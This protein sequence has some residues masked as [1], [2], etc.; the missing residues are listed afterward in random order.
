MSNGVSSKQA[1]KMINNYALTNKM[2]NI[3]DYV[4][5]VHHYKI[6]QGE[7]KDKRYKT[8]LVNQFTGK[9]KLIAKATKKELYDELINYYKQFESPTFEYIFHEWNDYR[10]KINQISQ[11]TWRR[12]R[13]EFSSYCKDIAGKK[14][15][16]ISSEDITEYCEKLLAKKI[17]TSKRWGAVKGVIK[18]TLQHA[19]RK[20]LITFSPNEPFEIMYI[21]KNSF[22]HIVRDDKDE[23]Y[24]DKELEI[25]IPYL[26]NNLDI[27]NL[28]ILLMFATGM[29]IGELVALKYEDI[30]SNSIS[31]N[32]M[33]RE[34]SEQ[35]KKTYYKVIDHAKTENSIRTIYVADNQTWILDK[36]KEY[37]KSKKYEYIFTY[38]R[39]RLTAKSIRNRL[40]YVCKNK[41][42]LKYKSPHKIRK[43]YA[44]I[45]L[46]NNVSEKIITSQLGHADI[47]TTRNY[48]YKDRIEESDKV[49]ILND[50]LQSRGIM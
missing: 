34:Y 21:N 33:E 6:W 47:T 22:K 46:D 10:L 40:N 23:V 44:S 36:L 16:N 20:K 18:G 14:I 48:Y 35:G 31:I 30:G 29:R 8:R 25:L 7:G 9:R 5:E 19:K 42:N 39:K 50:V 4:K 2:K 11:P 1:K 28:A 43:T 45:L 15:T 13:G 49:I 12:N 27:K 17:L 26:K 24:T 41:I 32:K 37:S 38:R 3:E